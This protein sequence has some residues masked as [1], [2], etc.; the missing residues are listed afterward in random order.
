ML[1]GKEQEIDFLLIINHMGFTNQLN[2]YL[3][4]YL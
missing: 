4:I 2:V 3:G 1:W